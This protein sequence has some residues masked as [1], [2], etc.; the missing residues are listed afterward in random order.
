MLA[1]LALAFPEKTDAE[2]EAIA[3]RS[4][5][6]LGRL[7]AEVVDAA[8]LARAAPRLRRARAG[9]GG[10][11][12]TRHRARAG[13]SCTSRATS[14]TGSSWPSGSRCSGSAP[15][16]IAKA[17]IDP[18]PERAH[19][20]GPRARA[21]SR[22]SGAR[23][24]RTARAMIRCF[25]QNRMLGILIDQDTRCRACSSR[26][27][28]GPPFTPRAAADLALRFRA[29]VVVGT[30]RRR[31][32]RPGDGHEVTALEVPF[33]ADA[34]RSRGRGRPADGCLLGRLED[35]HPPQPGGVGLDARALE[36]APPAARARVGGTQAKPMP[37]TAELSGG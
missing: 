37:K 18:R 19:R 16:P 20:A 23:T 13:A 27:S 34:A 6:H 28:G 25:K 8:A 22:R 4:L 10:G 5:V 35:G 11:P 29:P 31:G 26:S 1:Q 3:R 30:C 14:G 33:D 12:A 24:P 2:R 32:P 7:A 36:D 21:A 15:R 9:H 17:T